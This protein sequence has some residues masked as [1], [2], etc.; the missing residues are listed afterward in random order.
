M[1][2]QENKEVVYPIVHVEID[3]IK[4]HA[5]LD[6]GAGSSYASTKLINLLNKKPKG[7]A[8]KRIDMMHGSST[9]DGEIYSA[10]LGAIDGKFDMNID[11]TKVHKPQLLTLEN[12]NYPSLLSKYSHLKGVKIEENDARPQIPIHVMLGASEYA[13]V[14]TSTAQR[15]G[16]PGQPVAEKTL[17]G[18]TL[19][20]PGREDVGSPMLLTQSAL[21]DY[22]QLCILD[23]LG[24]AD[25]HENDQQAVYVEFKEQLER[26]PE[27]W[28]ETGLPW[29]GGHPA[30]PTNEA[31][32]KRRLEQLIRKLERNDQY[33]EYNN[34]IRG[35]LQEGIVEPAPEV[36]TG[37][38]FY[39]PHKGVNR[40]NAESTKL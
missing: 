39:I 17:L 32:S 10:I 16:K 29:K 11:L 33:E 13:T 36:P 26:N 8:T 31:G 21:T 35:Q 5:L 23:V 9:T 19:M 27:G 18:W 15:V 30:L 25:T 40:E 3:G 7:T 38:E 6:T 2:Q 20:S 4:T 12:P 22:E 14:K 24:L 37:T 34:I 28:Y 1:H